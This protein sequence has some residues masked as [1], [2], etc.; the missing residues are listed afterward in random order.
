MIPWL[1][2]LLLIAILLAPPL[3]LILGFFYA[4]KRR[5][6]SQALLLFAGCIAVGYAGIDRW[7]KESVLS[8]LPAAL[9]VNEMVYSEEPRWKNDYAR[10]TFQV[11]VLPH[12]VASTITEKS[13]RFFDPG[14]FGKFDG[15]RETPVVLDESWSVDLSEWSPET[16]IG[17]VQAYVC[18]SGLAFCITPDASVAKDANAIA[19]SP[20]SYY[21]YDG[22][23]ALLIVSPG[24]KRVIYM[25]Q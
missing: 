18:H 6:P 17:G 12:D 19:F 8:V 7:E 21:A 11:F 22:H 16:R 10:G 14:G 15:W 2:P 20:G 25:K 13:L 3:V 1:L 4:F 5:V 24:K 23:G 9:Q